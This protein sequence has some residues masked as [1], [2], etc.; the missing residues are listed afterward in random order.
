MNLYLTGLGFCVTG[1]SL[2]AAASA[3]PAEVGWSTLANA[4]VGV[5]IAFTARSFVGKTL[6]RRRRKAGHLDS[7]RV[8]IIGNQTDAASYLRLAQ[9]RFASVDVVD[10]LYPP[11]SGSF[12]PNGEHKGDVDS[13]HKLL[14]RE[15]V[16]EVVIASPFRAS[17]IEQLTKSCLE[18]GIAVRQ[19]KR[20][21]ATRI[22]RCSLQVLSPGSY[23]LSYDTLPQAAAALLLKRAVDILGA[24]AG[25]IF[26]G[27][28]YAFCSSAIRLS[29]RGS[30]IFCQ[31]RV[32]R[33]GRLF[34]LYKF[35]TM[36]V[37]AEE[38]LAA[39]KSHNQMQGFIFKMRDDPRVTRLGRIL[40]RYHI[41]EM[42]QFLNVLK[43]EMSLVGTRP[44]TPAEVACYKPYHWRRLSFKPGL[45]GMWQ[46][47]GNGKV[48]NFEDIVRLDCEYIDNWSLHLDI[49]ILLKTCAKLARADGW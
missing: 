10:F 17:T 13:L 18:R 5:A 22:G 42:P 19:I 43:G 25:L 9:S 21:P 32:G 40:R 12:E 44:P 6:L 48:S 15:V 38:R 20:M 36:H 7:W 39:L 1:A 14:Q 30:P 45:T 11:P 41:D 27:V 31:T 33:N 35:R 26:C 3:W 37:D 49:K 8:L 2:A 28:V 24:L 4:V 23:V 47:S 16:D 46:L 29:T 34:T